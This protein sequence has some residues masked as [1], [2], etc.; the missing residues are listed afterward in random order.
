MATPLVD[1]VRKLVNDEALWARLRKEPEQVLA[2]SGLSPE[3]QELMRRGPVDELEAK[4]IQEGLDP[5]FSAVI[6]W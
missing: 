5:T 3:D 6:I 4:L 1:F 2:E